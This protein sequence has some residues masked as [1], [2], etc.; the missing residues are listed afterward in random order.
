MQS[1]MYGVSSTVDAYFH[2]PHYLCVCCTHK[3]SCL[4]TL[5]FWRLLWCLRD[6]MLTRWHRRLFPLIYWCLFIHFSLLCV[7]CMLT[8]PSAS[9]LLLTLASSI[10]SRLLMPV[11]LFS[12]FRV[13]SAC[14]HSRLHPVFYWRLCMLTK[15][16]VSSIFIDANTVVLVLRCIRTYACSTSTSTDTA[17]SVSVVLLEYNLYACNIQINTGAAGIRTT[18]IILL[19]SDLPLLCECCKHKSSCL[20]LLFYWR[21]PWCLRD[22]HA[23]ARWHCRLS[24]LIYWRLFIHFSFLCVFC[25]LTQPYAFSLLL[26]PAYLFYLHALMPAYLSLCPYFYFFSNPYLIFFLLRRICNPFSIT[27]SAIRHASEEESSCCTKQIK[28]TNNGDCKQNT[29]HK[30]K[31]WNFCKCKVYYVT[32]VHTNSKFGY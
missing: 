32:V 17:L 18:I 1:S 10:F 2:L 11:Y 14:W 30:V 16:S 23:D 20:V 5:F 22:L 7:F 28:T 13:C 15:P 8:Q 26:T 12:L 19:F 27:P 29:Q 21:L 4:F 6:L 25:V 3:S 31:R 24:P 9:Y